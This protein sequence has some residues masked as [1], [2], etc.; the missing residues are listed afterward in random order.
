MI[1]SSPALRAKQTTTLA[2]ESAG[3]T[4]LVSFDERIYEASARLLFEIV[5]DFPDHI[6]TA[7]MIGHNP[8]FEEL[9]AVL[10]GQSQSMATAT[11]ACIELGVE[12]WSDVS[13]GCGRLE[14]LIRPKDLK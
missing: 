5:A 11:L 6:S 3:L 7:M 2:C 9:L 8:G 10:T 14:C 1:V 4:G 13:P 12:Q